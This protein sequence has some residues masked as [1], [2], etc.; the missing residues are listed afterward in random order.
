M[1]STDD[2]GEV[3]APAHRSAWP[4]AAG[5]LSAA[6]IA[7]VRSRAAWCFA[8]VWLGCAVLLTL[9]Q[10]E[11]PFDAVIPVAFA[12]V[13]SVV[14][15]A[16][17]D[18]PPELP[19]PP[20]GA[21]RARVLLQLAVVL[22]VFVLTAWSGLVFHD[23]VSP[24]DGPAAWSA[25]HEGIQRLGETLLG[26]GRGTWLSNPVSY[27]LLPLPLLLLAGA[28]PR[29]LGMG[30]GHRT[31]PV[32][33][34]TALPLLL[35]GLLFGQPAALGA[36]I[37]SNTMQNGFFEEFL[38]RGALQTRLRMLIVPDSALVVQALLFGAWHVGF[39]YTMT[40]GDLIAAVAYTIVHQGVLGVAFGVLFAR[41]RNL[42]A[43]SVVHVLLN[44]VG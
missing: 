26:P 22:V 9:R 24:S 12:L 36:R 33:L 4:T 38:F 28:R 41:T 15:I 37:V 25:V 21:A 29:E 5:R 35:A 16:L 18:P 27:V 11:A 10:G 17:T 39:G 7:L 40:G 2:D 32:L 19:R 23:V 14:T 34:A 6:A 42:L 13:V 31:G 44:S 30:R 3:D 20:S 43:P 8:L 1:S